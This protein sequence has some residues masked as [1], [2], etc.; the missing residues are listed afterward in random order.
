VTVPDPRLVLGDVSGGRVLDVAT[1]DGAFIR[2]LLDGLRDHGEIIGIDSNGAR[3]EAF[4]DAFGGRPGVRFERMDA[5]ALTFPHASFDTVCISNSLHHFADPLPVLA[6]MRRVLRSGG[7]LVINEMYRDGQSEAQMT[8]VLLHHWWAAVNL[9]HGDVHRETYRRAE[10]VAIVEGLGLSDL[11]LVDL[12]DPDQDPRDPA[13]LADLEAVIDR[14]LALADGS[15]D[16]IARGE[17]LRTRL[18]MVGVRD[19]TQLV[20]V[21]WA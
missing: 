19:A 2:F 1:G 3:A 18:R 5:H 15:P 6:E 11:R 13:T 14:Y 7:Q 21:G 9:L 10:L 17:M 20:A 12:A 4:A 16:L 8:H